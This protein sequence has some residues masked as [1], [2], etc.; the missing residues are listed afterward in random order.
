[1]KKNIKYLIYSIIISFTF[2]I[3]YN[4]NGLIF[5]IRNTNI[6]TILVFG[7]LIYTILKN[8]YEKIKYNRIFNIL[9]FIFSILMVAGY[10]F[11]T[12]KSAYLLYGKFYLIIISLI[13]LFGYYIFFKFVLNY[14][15]NYFNL[16]K[17]IKINSKFFNFFKNKFNKH[18]FL[19]CFIFIFICY[20]PY[21][22]IFYPTII[23]FD[24][25]NQIKEIMHIENRYMTSVNLIDPN[26]YITNF[27][28]V[29]HTFLLG[30][31][32]KLGYSIGNV[33]FG[34][35]LYSLIQ[36]TIVISTFSYS[37]YYL[38]K[39]QVKEEYLYI[40]L[41]IYSLIP[42]FPLYSITAVKDVIFSSF[43]LL[44]IIK[45]Y[46]F[47][48]N[49]YEFKDY[50]ILFLLIIGI[51]LFRNNGFYA[52][53]F[54]LPFL[55]FKHDNRK[56]I[57]ILI[58]STLIFNFSYNKVILPT[59]KITGTSVRETLSIPFQ[60]TA[61]LV[62]YHDDEIEEN[63]KKII[64]K[65]LDYS[66][67][68]NRYDEDLSDSVKNKFNKDATNEDLIAYF[69]V[70]SK[71]LFKNFGTYLEATI[72]NVYGYFYPN[73]SK[74]YVYNTYNTKLKE[75][76]FDYKFNSLNNSRKLIK[77]ISNA[78]PYIPIIGYIVNIGLTVWIYLFMLCKFIKDNKKEYIPLLIPLLTLV[79]TCVA[80]PV[81]TYYRYILPLTFSIFFIILCPKDEK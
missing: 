28:P 65:V 27:N 59:F 29:I 3:N 61:R 14:I 49:K 16:K 36:I 9:G 58:I 62:K 55:F 57:I 48:K 7:I 81:N 41:L 51:I 80:G 33:N 6:L 45:L 24:A 11:D 73:T 78:Y 35:F 12:I 5:N 25:A 22:I 31:L 79:L 4:K 50:I 20:L 10:S 38:K 66:D 39:Q 75:A 53:L 34:L 2:F 54:S 40:L 67:L 72:N 64:D 37:I 47:I 52:I 76:G 56:G 77:N 43:I 71:Y 8:N 60:Q 1:M 69:K 46:D 21:I 18:P 63:D 17:N 32:F 44:Y 74:W 15:Y 26:I 19:F 30:G 68:A 42:V 13:K 23:N 70:W